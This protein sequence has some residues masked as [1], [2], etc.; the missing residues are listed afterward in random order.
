MRRLRGFLFFLLILLVVVLVIVLAVLGWLTASE[1]KP[2]DV[3]S[4]EVTMGARHDAAEVGQ[5]Y[6]LVTL[7]VGYEA[8]AAQRISSWTAASL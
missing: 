7:N 1:Y 6:K 5:R 8:W 4:V 2:A 3:E